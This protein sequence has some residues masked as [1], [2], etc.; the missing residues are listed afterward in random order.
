MAGG[1]LQQ[2][3]RRVVIGGITLTAIWLYSFGQYLFEPMAA[4]PDD[5]RIR[6][7]ALMVLIAWPVSAAALLLQR[8]K[9]SEQSDRRFW[10]R[11]FYSLGLA[12]MLIHLAMA[13]HLG[14]AWSHA[15]AFDRTERVSGFGPGI[16]VSY[17]FT[18]LWIVEAVWMWVAFDRYLNRPAWLN[19]L[20][21]GFMWFVLLNASVIYG[22]GFVRGLGAMLLT[23]PWLMVLFMVRAHPSSMESRSPADRVRP[24]AEEPGHTP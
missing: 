19:W 5:P 10:I 14:H 4:N 17:F 21:V 9:P 24:P 18:L 22:T 16:F 2:Q 13:F 23:I 7:S 20:V 11:A 6:E 12:S 1:E 15:H 3:G 8:W